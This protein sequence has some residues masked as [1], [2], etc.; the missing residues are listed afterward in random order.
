LISSGPPVTLFKATLPAG[1]KLL[2]AYSVSRTSGERR[3]LDQ[4]FQEVL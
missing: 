2:E 4:H 3:F 1:G